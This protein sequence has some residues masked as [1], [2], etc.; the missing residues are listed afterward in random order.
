VAVSKA[1]ARRKQ[2]QLV[3]VKGGGGQPNPQQSFFRAGRQYLFKENSA[4]RQSVENPLL[5]D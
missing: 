4:K 1:S 3:G 5:D 2:D